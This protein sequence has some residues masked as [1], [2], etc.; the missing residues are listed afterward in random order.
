MSIGSHKFQGFDTSKITVANTSTLKLTD[1]TSTD[2][3]NGISDANTAVEMLAE[4]IAKL[5]D[6]V[7][8]PEI[9]QQISNLV[10][11]ME[12][13]KQNYNSNNISNVGGF[14]FPMQ[15]IIATCQ[16]VIQELTRCQTEA[17]NSMQL[18][19]EQGQQLNNSVNAVNLIVDVC[20]DGIQSIIQTI[21]T[22]SDAE[23]QISQTGES[24]TQ[25]VKDQAENIR[26]T[27]EF[28]DKLAQIADGVGQTQTKHAE[29]FKQILSEILT[30]SKDLGDVAQ[31]LS[32]VNDAMN[33]LTSANMI[34]VADT[35]KTNLVEGDVRNANGNIKTISDM[36][37]TTM[38]SIT[39]TANAMQNGQFSV[40][41][42]RQIQDYAN[43]FDENSARF[44][45]EIRLTL[46]KYSHD[47]DD[48]S[49]E[50]AQSIARIKL[51]QDSIKEFRDTT[52]TQLHE[53]FKRQLA[54][55]IN[56]SNSYIN[57]AATA[58]SDSNTQAISDII[59]ENLSGIKYGNL[60][61]GTDE[62]IAHLQY[63][64]GHNSPWYSLI[65]TGNLLGNKADLANNLRNVQRHGYAAMTIYDK[66]KD[67]LTDSNLSNEEKV[68]N[69]GKFAEANNPLVQ[70]VLQTGKGM[71]FTTGG[72]KNLSTEDKKTLE[73]FGKQVGEAL[74]LQTALITAI[75]NVDPNN[76]TLKQLKKD[77]EALV[78]LQENINKAKDSSTGL[79]NVFSTIIGGAKK[80]KNLFA[81]GLGLIGL[82]ALLS[83]MEMFGKGISYEE[84]E[85]RRRYNVARTDFYMGANLNGGR[86]IDIA[87]N[88][89]NEY[90]RMTN[91]MI[92]DNEYADYY[93]TLAH[94]S[95]GHYGASP[96]SA[97]SDMAEIAEKTFAIT[98]VRDISPTTSAGFMKSF[99]K[100]LG[101]SASEASQAL[102]DLTQT[103]I[104]SNVPVEKYVQT[105]TGMVDSLRNQGVI[106]T[107]VKATMNN[108][109][110]RHLRVEDAQ[111]LV[112]SQANANM[113]MA[114][115]LNGSAF[116]GMMA[117]Q[118]GDP[119]A[120]ATQGM[121]A[122][123]SNGNPRDDYWQLMGQ[124]VMTEANFMGAIGGGPSSSLGQLNII[125]SL[126]NRGYTHKDAVMVADAMS[127]GDQTLVADLLKKG[128]EHKDGGKQ[129]IAEAM[130]DA[131]EKLALAGQQVSEFQKAGTT[132]ADAQKKIGQAM[133]KYL[134]EPLK[135]F[136]EGF[137]KVLNTIVKYSTALIDSVAKFFSEHKEG[138]DATTDFVDQHT[139][140]LGLGAVATAGL[141]LYGGRKIIPKMSGAISNAL[142][143]PKAMA[144][145]SGAGK[146]SM[147]IGALALAGVAGG[148][149]YAL[150]QLV[151]MFSDGTAKAQAVD[152]S[153]DKNS[154]TEI[155][156]GFR[157]SSSS[158]NSS[159]DNPLIDLGTVGD[160]AAVSPDGS[161]VDLHHIDTIE[162]KAAVLNELLGDKVN[163][164]IEGV[165]TGAELDSG[166][167]MGQTL[168]KYGAVAG[169]VMTG[170]MVNSGV[171]KVL[172]SA[173]SVF[174]NEG[175]S[176]GF[177]S[178]AALGQK[179]TLAGIK[180]LAQGGLLKRIPIVG[181]ILGAGVNGLQ[182]L[183]AYQANPNEF[184][185]GQRL[186]RW[187]IRTGFEIGGAAVGGFIGSVA[188]P[189]GTAVGA[190]GGS[191]AG[192]LASDA[193]LGRLGLKS[194][195]EDFEAQH[196]KYEEKVKKAEEEYHG[197]KNNICTSNDKRER[198][199]REAL[200]KHE[201][202]IEDLTND[203][204]HFMNDLYNKLKSMGL[205]DEIAA[206][207]AA[208]NVGQFQQQTANDLKDRTK[209]GEAMMKYTEQNDWF[210]DGFGSD[211]VLKHSTTSLG[212]IGGRFLS[213]NG[214]QDGIKAL[215]DA[216]YG[217]GNKTSLKADLHTIEDHMDG[218]KLSNMMKTLGIEKAKDFG[219]DDKTFGF[220]PTNGGVNRLLTILEK[221]QDEEFRKAHSKEWETFSSEFGNAAA[222]LINNQAQNGQGF[223]TWYE[224]HL[225]NE[226]NQST[227]EDAANNIFDNPYGSLT[228]SRQAIL[229]FARSKIGG[230]YVYGG[231]GPVD[232][233]CSGLSMESYKAGGINSLLH[234]AQQ[235]YDLLKQKGGIFTDASKLTGADLVFFGNSPSDIT[236]VG[237]ATSNGKM[238]D[239]GSKAGITERDIS[240]FDNIVGYG[241]ASML[242]ANNDLTGDNSSSDSDGQPKNP[243]E[244]MEQL[245]KN[246][247]AQLK[248]I[249]EFTKMSDKEILS[250]YVATGQL[251]LDGTTAL[252]SNGRYLSLRGARDNFR[253]HSGVR[254]VDLFGVGLNGA[255]T[256][257][258]EIKEGTG[259]FDIGANY[260]E[261]FGTNNPRR[262][263]Q[264]KGYDGIQ[265]YLKSID[266]IKQ[267]YD[268][269]HKKQLEVYETA[270]ES[271]KKANEERNE[272]KTSANINIVS[273]GGQDSHL[274]KSLRDINIRLGLQESRTEALTAEVN[275]RM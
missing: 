76:A 243:A 103:A 79:A 65:T 185:M 83:P 42:Y 236:H 18:T 149:M 122:W 161:I 274:S 226:Q 7:K 54:E 191:Y 271:Q 9:T 138:V 218:S 105:V 169:A 245:T 22:M 143:S 253:L 19:V 70:S 219:F 61:M 211:D 180:G 99:Y 225:R 209:K 56:Y 35:L 23:R 147:G 133:H 32:S 240:T 176:A 262:T 114:N 170:S 2:V 88:K 8:T 57:S 249:A 73:S 106:G 266:E 166:A 200:S 110:N 49:G 53:G 40:G 192:T 264:L 90:W 220:I 256:G 162:E 165:P 196:K 10:S 55:Q 232:Y 224:Q 190:V 178:L 251:I 136:R 141:A 72:G 255:F 3:A 214:V 67:G 246:Y 231:V 189:V 139:V 91:G 275:A 146:V 263:I 118:G 131:K 43:G 126:K 230:K 36:L 102:V 134:S 11:Q 115:D 254:D 13:L 234:D 212:N 41:S 60:A 216:A 204:E 148:G 117:G 260:D 221:F 135:L 152:P 177:K 4:E 59:T 227:A 87:R 184:T 181:G 206:Y 195:S 257:T 160:G 173:G 154:L 215:L 261:Q 248:Q 140:S 163:S 244:A 68:A 175:F 89:S 237:I 21:V 258:G 228:A 112:Q 198:A 26:N 81:S 222:L 75:E 182:E 159:L 205:S 123:D 213:N 142:G 104:S 101:M 121:M 98:K 74:S 95:G 71:H 150:A 34:A 144:L 120:L 62:A 168:A 203:Q 29:D 77:Q 25:A 31:N 69:I 109:M 156:S 96:N 270:K 202:K 48:K 82:G 124:R 66:I 111:S 47:H 130:S 85:G 242:G 24:I 235:Q 94:G 172:K 153:A 16:T 17:Q 5:S 37:Q 199:A 127:K 28:S 241:N 113:N 233:D 97:A 208:N 247:D 46:E 50:V 128:E 137:E 188:G 1:E 267:S 93:S 63:S 108:L 84:E 27:V 20:N 116:W 129:T 268:E 252:G 58:G 239:A 158:D 15:Q 14:T 164:E 179:P 157:D 6:N 259:V 45:D 151:K 269:N 167:T 145:R 86:I 12:Q 197:A 39:A 194:E 250:D 119:I 80:L 155:A 125:D 174:K 44:L 187:G 51:M 201:T 107:Q 38:D 273:N 229:E 52:K 238:I 132:L 210:S 272:S 171:W 186:A 223:E 78:R 100:D 265:N 30:Y 92:G 193:I 64:S 183:Q 33:N 217:D 207:L